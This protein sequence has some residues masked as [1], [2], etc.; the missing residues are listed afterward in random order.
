MNREELES[1]KERIW[2]AYLTFPYRDKSEYKAFC[3]GWAGREQQIEA[4]DSQVIAEERK[5]IAN[6][7]LLICGGRSDGKDWQESLN[8]YI[9]TLRAKEMT[10]GVEV[11]ECGHE[12]Q[13][14]IYF[15]GACRTGVVICGCTGYSRMTAENE[16]RD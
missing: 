6:H 14:H 16:T 1:A 3:E 4:R 7:L 8:N 5:R 2:Q 11:C 15:E 9:E 13:D 10:D 12:Q